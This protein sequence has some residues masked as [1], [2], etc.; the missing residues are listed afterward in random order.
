LVPSR[1]DRRTSSGREIESALKQFGEPIGPAICQR[2]AF[3][4]ALTAGQW[5]G[6]YA[7]ESAAHDDIT[8]LALSV[9]RRLK[10]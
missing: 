4:D 6:E 1:I 9:K 10:L 7:P 8:A 2:S 5:I 3:I